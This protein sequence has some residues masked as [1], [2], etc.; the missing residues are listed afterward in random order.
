MVAPGGAAAYEEIGPS[1]SRV[2]V[3]EQAK[4]SLFLARAMLRALLGQ[5][6]AFWIYRLPVF[7]GK[8][9]RL[10]IAPQDLRTADATQAAE[11]HQGRF[12]FAGKVAVCDGRSPFEISPPSE[13]WAIGLHGFSW[14]RHLRT[15]DPA[16]SRARA[17]SLVTEWLRKVRAGNPISRR[18]EV[19]SR[20]IISWLTQAPLLVDDSDVRFYRRFIRSLNRQVRSLR[21]T[22]AGPRDGVPRLQAVIALVYASLCMQGQSRY[23]E[24]ST[25]QLI[26]ELDR[27]ILPDG[28]HIGR[29]PG[30]L[31]ELLVDLLP[32]RQAFSSR[33][34]PPPPSLLNAIDR[35]MPMLRFFRHG[36]GNFALFNGMGPT[37]TDLLTT[38][39]AY[40]DARGTPVSNAPH[41]GYQR[42]EAGG[43]L[44][45]MDTGRPPMLAASQEAHAG[46]LSFELSHR[47]FRILVNCGL[48]GTSREHWRA[49]ARSTAAHST[50]TF[51]DVSSCRFMESRLIKWLM[52]GTPIVSGPRQVT[53]NRDEDD[54][55]ATVLRVS[56][57]G[58]VEEFGILHQR[59]LML[60]ADGKRLDG[61]ELF[62]AMHGEA[63]ASQD[64]FAVRFHL[65][66]MIKANRLSDSH[67]A[68]LLLPNKDVWTFNAYE[69]RIDIEESVYLAGNEGP[70]RTTQIVIHG[71]SRKVARIQWTLSLTAASPVGLARRGRGETAPSDKS[72]VKVEQKT[73]A[74][75]AEQK[76]V[77]KV[78]QKAEPK[79]AP[80]V[81][82][83]IEQKSQ[84][85]PEPKKV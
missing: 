14:L 64:Q 48:P 32:L 17:R 75:K 2:S 77:Q 10:V 59:A 63:L 79:P 8:N 36:D 62:T 73:E 34:I 72:E 31:I 53:V 1:M 27:Q 67:G 11:I 45:L 56:H 71:R 38:V 19:I 15:S 55:S 68:M 3:T 57:D 50:V 58:Y 12:V 42:V 6:A 46:C 21:V 44:I 22:L 9:D 23:I 78:E 84:P 65:H 24:G 80:K 18:P 29:N 51:N 26:E 82:P 61:E 60:S 70:R 66:P 5:F 7:S 4:L 20:R 49:M 25:K 41:S 76:V 85:K 40:D 47:N 52:R 30:S 28:G 37:P 83:A 54:S 74:R 81:E 39:L 13:E 69:D 33:N 43:T 16:M 35:M